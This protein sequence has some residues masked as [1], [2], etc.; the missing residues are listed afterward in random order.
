MAS[1]SDNNSCAYTV[2]N[3]LQ[4]GWELGTELR[5]YIREDIGLLEDIQLDTLA[6]EGALARVGL[7]TAL[8]TLSY[9]RYDYTKKCSTITLTKNDYIG[10][11]DGQFT[12]GGYIVLVNSVD[13]NGRYG[14]GHYYAID[15]KYSHYRTKENGK[16]GD[17]EPLIEELLLN[18]N[19]RHLEIQ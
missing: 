5:R 14:A 6:I 10:C 7:Q 11:T 19:L 17:C 13:S 12:T 2:L 1:T 8:V 9:G 16:P 15:A 4:P 18:G 3:K